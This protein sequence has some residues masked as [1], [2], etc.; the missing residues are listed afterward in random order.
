MLPDDHQTTL[1]YTT[2]VGRLP[3]IRPSIV[4]EAIVNA[5][6]RASSIAEKYHCAISLN[7]RAIDELVMDDYELH[8]PVDCWRHA[9][10]KVKRHDTTR[11]L[12]SVGD[13]EGFRQPQLLHWSATSC[14]T[15]RDISCAS[16]ATAT[17]GDAVEGGGYRC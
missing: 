7:R 6:T 2:N 16:A 14:C 9:S 10:S 1:H 4:G 5:I 13:F 17:S 15:G 12:G 8:T 3:S 11:H